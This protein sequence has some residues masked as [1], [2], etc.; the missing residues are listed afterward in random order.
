MQASG[1]VCRVQGSGIL[2]CAKASIHRSG[3]QSGIGVWRA[4]W[5]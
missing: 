4:I 3:L 5:E 2:A 1:S